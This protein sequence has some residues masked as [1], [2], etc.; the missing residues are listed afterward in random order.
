MFLFLL[1]PFG[2]HAQ[3]LVLTVV[4]NS[5]NQTIWPAIEAAG[6]YVEFSDG[7]RLIDYSQDPLPDGLSLEANS[8]VKISLNSFPW[9]GRVW[10]RQYC[11]P[12][13]TGCVLGD[14]GHS[15]CWG[16]SSA[17]T[18]LFEITAQKDKVY[19]DISLVDGFTCGVYVEPDD[20]DCNAVACM[21][22]PYLG[23]NNNQSMVCPPP[24]LITNSRT[25]DVPIG[26]RSNCAIYKTDEY[27]CKG[28]YDATSCKGNNPWF[29]KTC[30][31]AYSYAYDDKDATFTCG[32]RNM[33]IY[34]Q[35]S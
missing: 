20:D 11:S 33:T 16:R 3:N 2:L 26:C 9:S 24:N 5:T 22:P 27:C 7:G 13:G 35:C 10:A 8:Q 19:Y 17:D 23:I 28:T 4:N 31:D 14:C 25:G 34:F 29:K 21:A 32:F 18:T 15:S 6:S 12:D 1:F 30:P